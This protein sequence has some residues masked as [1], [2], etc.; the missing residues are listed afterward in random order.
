L[1]QGA[2]GCKADDGE[3]IS[4][5]MEESFSF[6]DKVEVEEIKSETKTESES[7]S[8]EES[9][10][11]DEYDEDVAQIL[12]D[13]LALKMLATHHLHPEI[14]V[15][16][17]IGVRCYF[18]CASAPEVESVLEVEWAHIFADAAS[19]INTPWHILT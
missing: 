5:L 4:Q 13:A 14:P 16:S 9:G 11:E 10:D 15:A 7:D 3:L 2:G 18:H 12:S 1:Q 6:V 19:L 17:S 8:E